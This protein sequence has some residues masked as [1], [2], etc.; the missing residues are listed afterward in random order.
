MAKNLLRF[1]RFS[2]PSE[3]EMYPAV[4]NVVANQDFTLSIAFDN[5]EDG[6][7]DMNRISRS[8]HSER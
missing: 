7:L 2:N 3:D 6:V 4:T 5:G 1:N 8:V